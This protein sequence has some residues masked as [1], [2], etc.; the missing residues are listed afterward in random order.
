MRLP[1]MLGLSLALD[2]LLTGKQIDAKKAL[3]CGLVDQLFSATQSVKLDNGMNS[4]YQ[5]QWLSELTACL[6]AR[7][8]GK[9][10]FILKEIRKDTSSPVESRVPDFSQITEESIEYRQG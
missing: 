2:L 10:K 3:K 5:Y 8:I 7:K 9:Q 4:C 1:H 6:K